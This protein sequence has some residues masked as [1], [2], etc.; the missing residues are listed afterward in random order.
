M[1]CLALRVF[2]AACALNF[3]SSS[4]DG[5]HVVVGFVNLFNHTRLERISSIA[6]IYDLEHPKCSG[7]PAFVER[8]GYAPDNFC[9]HPVHAMDLTKVIGSEWWWEWEARITQEWA[10]VVRPT[11]DGKYDA[12]LQEQI[13]KY[14]LPLKY[15]QFA[16]ERVCLAK[17]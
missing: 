10:K 13:K 5:R 4:G 17:W 7:D 2:A 6:E 1:S 11:Y 16:L 14:G 9:V 12:A 8:T 15:D 3:G